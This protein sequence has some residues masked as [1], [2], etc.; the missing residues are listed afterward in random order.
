MAEFIER[1]SLKVRNAAL[2]GMIMGVIIVALDMVPAFS[3]NS[4]LF[5]SFA[6]GTLGIWAFLSI[7][8]MLLSENARQTFRNVLAFLGIMSIVYYVIE[9]IRDSIVTYQ[10]IQLLSE[11]E[12]VMLGHN[13]QFSFICF[14]VKRMIFW[15]II[16]L[17]SAAGMY[18]IV[19]AKEKTVIYTILTAMPLA[20]MLTEGV[21][22]TVKFCSEF[23]GLAPMLCDL[24]GFV[25]CF[26]CLYETKKKKLLA[27]PFIVLFSIALRNMICFNYF[28]IDR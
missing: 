23:K 8:L 6:S 3:L 19:A 15:I 27:V 9:A 26:I 2:F 14:S 7:I 12:R 5:L 20:V 18:I 24:L 22:Y 1:K 4:F 13:G 10:T 21:K 17:I 16:S 11:A 25:I 28:F